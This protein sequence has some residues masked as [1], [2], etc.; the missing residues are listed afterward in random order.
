MFTCVVG[1]S[2]CGTTLLRNMMHAHP[3]L[4]MY[5]ES[6][7]LPKLVEF[8]GYQRVP[9]ESILEIVEKTTWDSGI[10]LLSVNLEYSKFD[11][12]EELLSKLRYEFRNHGLLTIQDFSSILTKVLFD[13]N[14]KWGDKTPDYG[15]FMSTIQ[16]LW[17]DCKFIHTVRDGLAVARSMSLHPGCQLQVS[18]GYDNWCSLS[19]DGLYNRYN[20]KENPI[21]AYIKTWS[22]RMCRIRDE[23]NQLSKGTYLELD[24]D[25]LLLRPREVL[26]HVC[27]F[28]GLNAAPS[29]ISSCEDMIKP[30]RPSIALSLE[31]I[32]KLNGTDLLLLNECENQPKWFTLECD[33]SKKSI[34]DHLAMAT[35]WEQEGACQKA[36][37]CFFDV[38]ATRHCHS[39]P[40]LFLKMHR[41]IFRLFGVLEDKEAACHWRM[42]A[43]QLGMG[44]NSNWSND[45]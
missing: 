5:R 42:N 14:G 1:A 41:E 8:F 43:F 40:V 27:Q 32:K 21:D 11:S 45:K 3:E 13:W 17:P 36:L 16:G 22:R 24:Y 29:W 4:V 35:L 34:K 28:L 25:C 10:D 20:I 9:A 37:K 33:A 39:T 31:Q 7:W 6:H 23:A 30:K 18:A 19:Y 12:K 15:F 26:V 44:N 38:L 2:R